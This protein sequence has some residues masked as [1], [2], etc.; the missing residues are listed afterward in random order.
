M[1]KATLKIHLKDEDI[2]DGFLER[3]GDIGFGQG[4]EGDGSNL[5][6]TITDEDNLVERV[7]S[8]KQAMWKLF[9]DCEVMSLVTV[10][11]PT[12]ETDE[13]KSE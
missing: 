11:Y 2:S 8:F 7:A 9:D 13:D 4:A 12:E 10:K 1:C 5:V 6:Y 3:I